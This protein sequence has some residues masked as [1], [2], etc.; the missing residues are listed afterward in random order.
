MTAGSVSYAKRAGIYVLKFE[1]AI[2][3]TLGHALDTFLDRLF[4]EGDFETILVDLTAAESI[5][6]TGLGLL[7]K[8][9]NFVRGRNGSKP[10]LFCSNPDIN[11]VLKAIC[12][13]Q[14]FVLCDQAPDLGP[15]EA[16]PETDPSK[17]D[18]ARTVLGAHRLLCEMN[19]NNRALFQNVVDVL[20]KDLDA[21]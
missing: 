9:A 15:G 1:G 17:T 7:A 8:I 10:L 4:A 6:S 16:L 18:L 5:D 21:A 11:E 13:D 20:E 2:R 19:E 14:V 3:Y 12:M